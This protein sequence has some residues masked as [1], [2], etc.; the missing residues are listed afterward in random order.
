M[1]QQLLQPQEHEVVLQGG[2]SADILW[3]F[4]IRR[5]MQHR[6]CHSSPRNALQL[7]LRRL[8]QRRANEVF[9]PSMPCLM[10][11]GYVCVLPLV[12]FRPSAWQLYGCVW[13]RLGESACDPSASWC[14]SLACGRFKLSVQ[15]CVPCHKML[16]HNL[17]SCLPAEAA[18]ICMVICSI[19]QAS[20][21][22]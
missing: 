13:Q 11:A 8:E 6:Q 22:L 1:L 12:D 3:P 16:S 21:Y 5:M 19:S 15:Y 2:T 7:N 20:E 14:C 9:L 17:L 10:L 4:Q 18:V